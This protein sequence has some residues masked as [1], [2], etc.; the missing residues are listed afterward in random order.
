LSGDILGRAGQRVKPLNS[1]PRKSWE[2]A[3]EYLRDGILSERLP[4]GTRL[5]EMSIAEEIGLSQGPVREALARLE[6][7]GLIEAV[8]RRGRY[9]ASVPVETGR[10]LYDLRARVEPF[11]AKLAMV[12]LTPE[13][14]DQLERY[15][16]LIRSSKR[17]AARVDAD[18]SF[19]RMIYELSHFSPLVGL[20]DQIE[21]L[22]RRL[23]PVSEPAVTYDIHRAI[24]EAMRSK[25]VALL[26][27]AF[28]AH[29]RQTWSPMLDHELST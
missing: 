21:L 8:G 29:M 5:V 18:M 13:N 24:L 25:D 27:R 7:Q 20:W 1:A 11:A 3:Y 6:E 26:E 15:V 2:V 28:D 12:S 16:E 14:L 4:P 17:V 23:R 10:L 22:T 9:V 19:H